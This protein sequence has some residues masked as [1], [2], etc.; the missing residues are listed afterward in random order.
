M[1]SSTRPRKRNA[2]DFMIVKNTDMMREVK[3]YDFF[4]IT[5]ETYSRYFITSCES[6]YKR[7][8]LLNENLTPEHWFPDI[9]V[10]NLL[11]NNK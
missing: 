2:I 1:G 6:L 5:D 11:I 9:F 7:I 8:Y 4:R 10:P 3:I